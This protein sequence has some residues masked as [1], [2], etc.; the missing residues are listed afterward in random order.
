M[1]LVVTLPLAHAVKM[2]IFD[3]L[4]TSEL[5]LSCLQWLLANR[6]LLEMLLPAMALLLA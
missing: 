2:Q 1:V 3:M 6:I 5:Y 4:H